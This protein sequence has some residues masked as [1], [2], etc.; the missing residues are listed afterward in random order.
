MILI[1]IPRT[2]SDNNVPVFLVES[3]RPIF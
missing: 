1:L 3:N 2:I